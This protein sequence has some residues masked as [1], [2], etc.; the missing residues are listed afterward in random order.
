MKNYEELI[1][2][3]F[4][5]LRATAHRND[6]WRIWFGLNL[7]TSPSRGVGLGGILWD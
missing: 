7:M 1:R 5:T 2:F 6:T 3:P 4:A